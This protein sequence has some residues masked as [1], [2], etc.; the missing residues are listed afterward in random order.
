MFTPRGKGYAAHENPENRHE[1]RFE[2]S[3]GG[4]VEEGEATRGTENSRVGRS[5]PLCED[6]RP[7]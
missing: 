7:G 5:E 4:R 6:G 1:D 3:N 2:S